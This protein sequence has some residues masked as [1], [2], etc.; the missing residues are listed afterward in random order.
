MFHV[1]L[2]RSHVFSASVVY[3]GKTAILVL[4]RQIK[5]FIKGS[6]SQYIKIDM[7]LKTE[8]KKILNDQ[9]ET[10]STNSSETKMRQQ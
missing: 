8:N 10:K 3:V 4:E 6:S 1:T 5:E 7:W 9:T 2:W